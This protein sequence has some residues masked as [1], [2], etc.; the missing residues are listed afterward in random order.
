MSKMH[1]KN[2]KAKLYSYFKSQKTPIKSTQCWKVKAM[3][4]PVVMYECE[5]S[6]IRKPSRE[7]LTL[8]DC[9]VGEDGRAP[10]TAR[11]SKPI[12]PR[13]NQHWIFIGRTDAGAPMLCPP[14][15]KSWLTGKDPDAG[16]D[17]KQEEKGMT[18]DRT[19]S[20]TQWIWAWANSRRQWRRTQ[21]SQCL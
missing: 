21:D 8:P 20:P 17:W 9:G 14:D 2:S 19:A 6:A 7:E 3:V 10:W 16:K 1:L 12:H 15:A 11:R 5:S 18:E 4:F 13:G